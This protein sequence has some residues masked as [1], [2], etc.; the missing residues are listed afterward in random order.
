MIME[1][2]HTALIAQ[3]LATE[4]AT[5]EEAIVLL[6]DFGLG[7]GKSMNRMQ[8]GLAKQLTIEKRTQGVLYN[9]VADALTRLT[10]DEG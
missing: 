4:I 6:N 10:E 9:P 1:D 3:G 2:F 7:I 8:K 5:T